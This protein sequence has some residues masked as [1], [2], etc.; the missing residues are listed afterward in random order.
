M[1]VITYTV[2]SDTHSPHSQATERTPRN[3]NRKHTAVTLHLASLSLSTHQSTGLSHIYIYTP[4]DT[5]T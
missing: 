5:C 1:L 4:T 2:C 3:K